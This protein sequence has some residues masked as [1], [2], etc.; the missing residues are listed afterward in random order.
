MIFQSIAMTGGLRRAF[1]CDFIKF[2]KKN[3]LPA[4]YNV[5]LLGEGPRIVP[6]CPHINLLPLPI[7]HF[8][9]SYHLMLVTIPFRAAVFYSVATI[10]RFRPHMPH[11]IPPSGAR[12]S[13]SACDILQHND[14]AAQAPDHVLARS[15]L[16]PDPVMHSR[17]SIPDIHRLLSAC[18]VSQRNDEAVQAPYLAALHLITSH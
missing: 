8:A 16:H 17:F 1:E 3:G 13:V 10:F 14:G 2:H 9:S 7:E 18:D 12:R 15:N 5:T 11:S 6:P 4:G